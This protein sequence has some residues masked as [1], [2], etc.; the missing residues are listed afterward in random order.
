MVSP[1]NQL[2]K[3]GNTEVSKRR[4][5]IQGRRGEAFVKLIRGIPRE[6]I[7]CVSIDVHKYYHQVMI[8]NEY[9]EILEPSFRIDIFR[10][11]FERLCQVIDDAVGEH[12]I[13]VLFIGMEP[14]GH[15]FE[16]LA[17]RAAGGVCLRR[18]H[19]Q[20][21]RPGKRKRTCVH[22]PGGGRVLRRPLPGWRDPGGRARGGQRV[23]LAVRGAGVGARHLK[24]K[25]L[26]PV[27]APQ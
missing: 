23:W 4:K 12:G 7:A 24:G 5:H 19:A 22:R 2:T 11:G 14:T 9:G 16:N 15:Y 3:R 10:E 21:M 27:M 6:R 18:P 13:Q 1:P 20:G 26:A 25:C 17:R 8:H